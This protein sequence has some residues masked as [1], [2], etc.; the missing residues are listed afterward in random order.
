MESIPGLQ[1]RPA[2]LCSL[3]TQFQTR[4][5]ESIPG[6][7]K[8]LVCLRAGFFEQS[9]GVYIIW[10]ETISAV[11]PPPPPLI[12][13]FMF[14]LTGLSFQNS[15]RPLHWEITIHEDPYCDSSRFFFFILFSVLCTTLYPVLCPSMRAN[16]GCSYGL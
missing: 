4:F 13:S 2:S 16:G 1:G 6:L 9:V 8:R 7:H 11:Q 12:H 15:P 5:L 14:I 10:R 3:A